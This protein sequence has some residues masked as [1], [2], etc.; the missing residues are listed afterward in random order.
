MRRPHILIVDDDPAVR[1][2][3]RMVLGRQYS[4]E[5]A[6]SPYQAE[7]R[8]RERPPDLVLLDL[9]LRGGSGL[10]VLPV[11]RRNA[12]ETAVVIITA[13]GTY[14]ATLEA[15][16]HGVADFL[17]KDFRPSELRRRIGAVFERR[18]PSRSEEQ[19][20][21]PSG[22]RP[23]P[24]GGMDIAFF[25]TLSRVME[26]QDY[27]TAGHS[28]RVS[29]YA[30]AV[31]RRLGLEDDLVKD[32]ELASFMHDVGKVGVNKSVL[33][34]EGSFS[35]LDRVE[36]ERHPVLGEEIIKPLG[37]GVRIL[38]G[39]RHHHERLDGSGYPDGIG[40][41]EVGLLPRIIAVVDSFD[42][43]TWQRLY[44]PIPISPMDALAALAA[45]A[46]SKYDSDVVAA[47]SGELVAGG[48]DTRVD[49][50]RAHTRTPA[51]EVPSRGPPPDGDHDLEDTAGFDPERDTMDQATRDIL[52]DPLV[53][54]ARFGALPDLFANPER[55]GAPV[56]QLLSDH[57]GPHAF[58][59]PEP[60]DGEVRRPLRG[61]HWLRLWELVAHHHLRAFY[62]VP[63][64][65]TVDPALHLPLAGSTRDDAWQEFTDGERR[66]VAQLARPEP[67]GPIT[68]RLS[69]G[70]V[71][72][73]VAHAQLRPRRAWAAS[74]EDPVVRVAAAW[75][76]DP[77]N[78]AA[79]RRVEDWIDA[80]ARAGDFYAATTWRP[81]RAQDRQR[82]SL[83]LSPGQIEALA[84]MLDV[85]EKARAGH[86]LLALLRERGGGGEPGA[87]EVTWRFLAE[88]S[89]QAEPLWEGARGVRLADLP[90][91]QAEHAAAARRL[92][93]LGVETLEGATQ[94][95][96]LGSLRVVIEG[97]SV[98]RRH[99][100]AA[101][102][103]CAAAEVDAASRRAL[104]TLI[105]QHGVDEAMGLLSGVTLRS[106]SR[107]SGPARDL[108]KRVPLEITLDD[109]LGR[110]E[111]LMEQRD[112]QEALDLARDLRACCEASFDTL[113]G[114]R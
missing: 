74:H 23:Q 75:M 93:E 42:A 34:K 3:F 60:T 4:F 53:I 8:L 86:P 107:L 46:P 15:F 83:R 70:H 57:S 14:E 44:R 85:P 45:E 39:V 51:E 33:N 73:T 114:R 59:D 80:R 13:C 105:T 64:T 28:L 27:V 31:A 2:T 69:S 32:L 30:V 88:T 35:R 108:L 68:Y 62:R 40:G 72:A 22:S 99:L 29:R 95:R 79:L 67:G 41:S 25:S 21:P 37:Y 7:L 9:N 49:P 11:L 66:Y 18:G 78:E 52:S 89:R 58:L 61:R 101:G 55:E 36:V 1:S 92:D 90:V 113:G 24:G 19:S 48:I 84:S 87:V 54:R 5:E 112:P 65:L 94:P 104:A 110:L 106:L 50:I 82:A 91:Y 17:E 96:S 109:T 63:G 43:M 102:E 98:V 76:D 56:V 20:A 12:P 71:R 16:Q 81:P 26:S 103:I 38:R 47:L 10:E 77:A 97:L 111:E 100:A 6:E